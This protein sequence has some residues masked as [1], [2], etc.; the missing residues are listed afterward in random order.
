MSD[1]RQAIR[2]AEYA[3]ATQYAPYELSTAIDLLEKA[4]NK[5]DQRR[6]DAA[7][8]LAGYAREAAMRAR[9]VARERAPD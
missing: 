7:R 3:G 2:S 8:E 6:F 9:D 4:Q 5:L 1:A